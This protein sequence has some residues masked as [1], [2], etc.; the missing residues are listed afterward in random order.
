MDYTIDDVIRR[1]KVIDTLKKSRLM[2]KAYKS[3]L[4]NIDLDLCHNGRHSFIIYGYDDII[5]NIEI[6]IDN[7]ENGDWCLNNE[8][9]SEIVEKYQKNS[10]VI[11]QKEYSLKKI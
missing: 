4:N 7:I 1:N 10:T 5:K 11:I 2:I 9:C 6:L 3:E 8:A